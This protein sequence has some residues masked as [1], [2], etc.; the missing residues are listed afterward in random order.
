M[1]IEELQQKLLK[2]TKNLSQKKC[3]QNRLQGEQAALAHR[4]RTLATLMH[5][6]GKDSSEPAQVPRPLT[7]SDAITSSSQR[8]VHDEK[9]PDAVISEVTC[10][11]R[12]EPSTGVHI[13]SPYFHSY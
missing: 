2:A 5:S 7:E 6:H 3:E 10:S 9:A 8:Q 13:L 12:S 1:Q 11:Q 4:L